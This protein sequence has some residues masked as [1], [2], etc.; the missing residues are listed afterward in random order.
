MSTHLSDSDMGHVA[1]SRLV[2]GAFDRRTCERVQNGRTLVLQICRKLE[3]KYLYKRGLCALS[4]LTNNPLKKVPPVPFLPI[5]TLGA[6]CATRRFLEGINILTSFEKT[7]SRTSRAYLATVGKHFQRFGAP[8]ES[9][10]CPRELQEGPERTP[11]TPQR[12]YSGDRAPKN[13]TKME[14]QTGAQE[15]LKSGGL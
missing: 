5:Q 9:S 6:T 2:G 4:F 14:A 7:T 1:S 8:S 11:G 3:K 15:R 12:E 13:G 10:G